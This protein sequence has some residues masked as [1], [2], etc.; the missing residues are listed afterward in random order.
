MKRLFSPRKRSEEEQVL[1]RGNTLNRIVKDKE[2]VQ[3]RL[4]EEEKEFLNKKRDAERKMIEF[5]KQVCNFSSFL[6]QCDH[7]F[8]KCPPCD[9]ERVNSRETS[10]ARQVLIRLVEQS[11]IYQERNQQV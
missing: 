10:H 6:M 11:R 5:E 9:Q 4:E 8:S 3:L 2:C 1:Q 7:H